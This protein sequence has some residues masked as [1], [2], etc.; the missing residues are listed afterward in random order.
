MKAVSDFR[1]M[2]AQIEHLLSER[3]E[4]RSEVQE[5]RETVALIIG[6]MPQGSYKALLCARLATIPK[7]WAQLSARDRAQ[8]NL[9]LSLAD[10]N[11][12]GAHRG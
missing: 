4:L 3:E 10:S 5:W 8:V 1:S 2:R 11:G 6:Q 7:L 9:I 12:K